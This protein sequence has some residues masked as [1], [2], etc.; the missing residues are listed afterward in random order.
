MFRNPIPRR[1]FSHGSGS[2]LVESAGRP[3]FTEPFEPIAITLDERIQESLMEAARLINRARNVPEFAPHIKR[4]QD[5]F[6]GEIAPGA[7][8]SLE[9]IPEEEWEYIE[10]EKGPEP[11][12]RHRHVAPPMTADD[13]YNKIL[14]TWKEAVGQG[15]SQEQ[16]DEFKGILD[17]IRS[18]W[19]AQPGGPVRGHQ[20]EQQHLAAYPAQWLTAGLVGSAR[21][22]EKAPGVGS[23]D[24]I[25]NAPDTGA[26]ASGGP[27]KSEKGKGGSKS[28]GKGKQSTPEAGPSMG[29]QTIHTSMGP[30]TPEH[31]RGKGQ[32]RGKFHTGKAGGSSGED[33]Q[34]LADLIPEDVN[35]TWDGDRLLSEG[36]DPED[37]DA[38]LLSEAD[39]AAAAAATGGLTT[40][41]Q[42]TNPATKAY[43]EADKAAG[44]IKKQLEVIQKAGGLAPEQAQKFLQFGQFLAK[45]AQGGA[46]PQTTTRTT[47]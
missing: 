37:D 31:F 21:R 36:Y 45:A 3:L 42:L 11:K 27:G 33:I 12:A 28:K 18:E 38:S 41:Q 2:L 14:D 35:S 39:D 15:L 29:G 1:S 34:R 44:V 25:W 43:Q 4:I 19:R 24:W 7:Q 20:Y 9:P 17:D 13:L 8:P 5:V 10:G 6:R 47:Q 40:P 46:K 22:F 16:F 32:G 26:T 30:I 23:H